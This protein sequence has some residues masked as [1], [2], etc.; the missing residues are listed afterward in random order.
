MAHSFTPFAPA[1]SC[2]PPWPRLAFR[3]LMLFAGL[4]L[5]SAFAARADSGLY[6]DFVILRTSAGGT[7][8]YYTYAGIAVPNP[9]FQNA[10]LG[11]FDPTATTP[12]LVLDGAEATTYEGNG[13]V[14]QA[15]RLF[16]RVYAE[17][18]APGRFLPVELTYRYSGIQ[19][20]PKTRKWYRHNAG[21]T[22]V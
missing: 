1:R 11:V 13:A 14:M 15:A 20:N 9:A 16:Y 4:F 21:L 17:G 7:T 18:T 6:K 8:Y 3:L 10:D 22:L 5:S 2:A 12:G 19:R